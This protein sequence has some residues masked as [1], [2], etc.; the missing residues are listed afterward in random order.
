ML[1]AAMIFI[2]QTNIMSNLTPVNE[3]AADRAK[4]S[5]N[6]LLLSYRT[7]RNLIGFSG[8]ILPFALALFPKRSSAWYGIEPSISDYFYTDRGDLLVVILSILGVFLL[9]YYGYNRVERILTLLAAIS[10]LGVAFVPTRPGCEE[11]LGSV[12][13]NSGG[14]FGNLVGG[15][16]HITFAAIFLLSLAIMSLVFFPKTDEPDL[17]KP[18]G[19]LTQK[20]KRNIVFRICGYTI[21]ACVVIMAAY[22]I[23]KPG[24][25]NFPLVF[26]FETI[27]V[28]AFALSWLTKGETFWPDG[29]HYLVKAVRDMKKV[30]SKR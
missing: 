5:E 1:Y 14:V 13:T 22:F 29:P 23:V 2:H 28:E 27:A 3:I 19:T 18:D 15:A 26:V 16:W 20:G 9:T 6:Q 17:R 11:C 4:E 7:L 8:M 12:H 21:I 30:M 10:G 25:N 24:L